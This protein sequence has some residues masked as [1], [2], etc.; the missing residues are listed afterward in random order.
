MHPSV[1]LLLREDEPH[2]APAGPD[3]L[4]L[5]FHDQRTTV[6]ST[7]F[8]VRNSAVN[9]FNHAPRFSNQRGSRSIV[10]PTRVPPPPPNPKEPEDT[11]EAIAGWGTDDPW[12]TPSPTEQRASGGA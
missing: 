1:S 2:P 5:N 10:P 6:R 8:L 3:T 12:G 11:A 9:E 4:F 7:V